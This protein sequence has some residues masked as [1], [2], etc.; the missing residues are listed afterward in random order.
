MMIADQHVS[1]LRPLAMAVG[2]TG[3]AVDQFDAPLTLS[4][5]I[6]AEDLT[7]SIDS[8]RNQLF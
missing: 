2:L 7:F 8:N 1:R 4:I 6:Y 5:G 3:A